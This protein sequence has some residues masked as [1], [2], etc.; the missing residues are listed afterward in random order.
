MHFE[1]SKMSK[2]E[3]IEL[4]SYQ[5]AAVILNEKCCWP[6]KLLSEAELY[7]LLFEQELYE[8]FTLRAGALRVMLYKSFAGLLTAPHKFW[9]S[10]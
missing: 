8:S 4:K 6:R 5:V 10:N 3:K 7:E 2:Y 9:S 1:L